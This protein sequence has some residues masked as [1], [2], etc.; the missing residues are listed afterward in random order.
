MWEGDHCE[1]QYDDVRVPVTNLLGE[2][3]K[4]FIMSQQRLGPGRITHCMRWLGQAERAFDLMCERAVRREAFGGP[5]ADKQLIQKMVFD[6]AAE[7]K[8][9]RMLTLEAARRLDE[10]DAGRIDVGMIKVVGAA[11]VNNVIDRAIQVHGAAGVT[12]DFPLS[13]MWRHARTGRILDGPDETHVAAVARLI[14]RPYRQSAE[15]EKA[16]K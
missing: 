9:A 5:L 8:A 16:T 6:S 3:G 1:V 14:L 4:G 7:I 2:R 15:A 11:M 12:D 10:G 13:R